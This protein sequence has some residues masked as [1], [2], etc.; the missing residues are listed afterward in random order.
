[1]FIAGAAIYFLPAIVATSRKH[2]NAT[3]ICVLDLLLGWTLLG[4]VIAL[5]WAFM[6]PA[7]VVV[8]R[9]LP[10]VPPL[11]SRVKNCPFCAEPIQAAAVKCKHCGSDLAGTTAAP[12]A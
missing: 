3:A 4:W 2:P 9:Q 10:P 11:V 1:M 12:R 5:V 8:K 7:Q 6:T